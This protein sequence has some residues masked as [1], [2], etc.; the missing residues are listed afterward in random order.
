MKKLLLVFVEIRYNN[1]SLVG[2]SNDIVA[3]K[4][5]SVTRGKMLK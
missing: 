4:E 5:D 3:I 2:G 1:Y